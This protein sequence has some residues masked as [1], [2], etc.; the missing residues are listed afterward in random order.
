MRSLDNIKT[1][2]AT[3]KQSLLDL[4][5]GLDDK[6]C[7]AEKLKE[8]WRKKVIPGVLLMFFSTLLN[9]RLRTCCKVLTKVLV[10]IWTM[11][12][13]TMILI[14]QIWMKEWN[15]FSKIKISLKYM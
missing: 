7:D 8:A 13:V 14:K 12:M 1:A 2:P 9:L 3:I 4:D 5:F 10:L 15:H 11:K 6:F